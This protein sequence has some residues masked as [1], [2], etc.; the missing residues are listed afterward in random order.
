[1]IARVT[2]HT[3]MQSAQRNL[4]SNMAQLAKL[5]DQASSQKA[6]NRPSDN[7][8]GAAEAM[9]VRA[10]IRA[11]EQYGR[12]I[13]D[14]NGWLTAVDSALSTSTDIMNQVRDLTIQAGNASLSPSGKQ[15]LAIEL[16]SL[17]EDLLTLTNTRYQGRSVFAG[18][19]DVSKVFDP[20]TYAYN[21][22]AGTVERRIG[23]DST[24]QVD[25]SGSDAFGTGT[26]SAFALIDELIGKLNAGQNLT[27]DDITAVDDRM[28]A[29]STEHTKIGTRHAQILRAQEANMEQSVALETKRS[30]IEDIDLAEV[31]LELKMQ[32][33]SYQSALSVTARV[34]Q[35]TLM[36][37]LR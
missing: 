31:I 21:G 15:A 12:N 35:P 24:V 32:E 8:A 17:K 13:T 11:S 34:L 19:S 5:Q 9:R 33:V 36:D 2:N 25:A 18:T 22:S 28:K 30:G 23:A 14:A 4:Q 29:I 6:F 7:P 1:M 16:G 27:G 26:D 37:F 3:L 20:N 10:E